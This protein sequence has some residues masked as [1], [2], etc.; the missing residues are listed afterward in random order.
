MLITFTVWDTVLLVHNNKRMDPYM[1]MFR[2]TSLI[3]YS[4]YIWLIHYW[5]T[6]CL[7]FHQTFSIYLV[8]SSVPKVPV[9]HRSQSEADILVQIRKFSTKKVY[10]NAVRTSLRE[11]VEESQYIF[12]GEDITTEQH[13]RVYM[14]LC[15]CLYKEKR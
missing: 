9:S 10:L 7:K 5:F 6:L 14:D 11:P 1:T 13:W 4:K 15:N 2:G 12:I 8:T 3:I